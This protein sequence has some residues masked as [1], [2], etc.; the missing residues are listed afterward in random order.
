MFVMT[1]PAFV[2][3]MVP[4]PTTHNPK[5][6]FVVSLLALLS[7]IALAIY[8]FRKI[9]TKKLNPLTDELYSDTGVYQKIIAENR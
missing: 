5:A 8:Q 4:V 2:D 6:F 1:V 9:I 3:R 7:N